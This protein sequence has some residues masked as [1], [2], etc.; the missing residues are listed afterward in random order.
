V[1]RGFVTK[2]SADGAS[3]VYSTYLGGSGFELGLRI[4]VDAA[5]NAYVTG[6]ASPDF[7]TANAFQP[8]SGGGGADAFVTKISP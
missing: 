7:P 8:T 5:G 4:A 2:F 6:Q 3:L 1:E